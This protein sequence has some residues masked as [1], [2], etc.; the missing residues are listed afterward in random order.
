MTLSPLLRRLL[1]GAAAL[2]LTAALGLCLAAG[3]HSLRRAAPEHPEAG[4]ARALDPAAAPA[5]LHVVFGR[6]GGSG[7]MIGHSILADGT[8]LAWQGRAVEQ[9]PATLGRLADGRV[10][11][12]WSA[13]QEAGFFD[14]DRQELGNAVAFITVR[15]EGRSHRIAWV[16]ALG[17]TAAT[18]PAEELYDLLEREVDAVDRS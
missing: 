6:T 2:S 1:R 15:A 5:D 13:I 8:V 17:D 7:R 14:E 16:V 9:D 18:T 4:G 12:L 10:A 11:E 3:C